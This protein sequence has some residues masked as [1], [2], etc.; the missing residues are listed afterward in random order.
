MQAYF[1]EKA[2]ETYVSAA[3]GMYYSRITPADSQTSRVVSSHTLA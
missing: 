3:F 1:V 2:A